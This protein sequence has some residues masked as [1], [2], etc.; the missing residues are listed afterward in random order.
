M[1]ASRNDV[2]DQELVIDEAMVNGRTKEPKTLASASSV[3]VPPDLAIELK[4]YLETIDPSPTA[5]L[6]PS[7]HKM[8]RSAR[9]TFS[10]AC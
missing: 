3:F 8:C 1:R 9:R 4:H 7:S 2:R 10:S 6:F 5:W